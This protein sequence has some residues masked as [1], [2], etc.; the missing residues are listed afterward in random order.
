[1]MPLLIS[2]LILSCVLLQARHPSL[3]K[4]PLNWSHALFVGL[5][6]AGTFGL[7][8]L[9]SS[10]PPVGILIPLTLAATIGLRTYRSLPAAYKYVSLKVTDPGH[11]DSIVIDAQNITATD[12]P[13]RWAALLMRTLWSTILGWKVLLFFP[14]LILFGGL[15]GGLS[16]WAAGYTDERFANT[17][18]CW[19]MLLAILPAVMKKLHTLD[20]LPISR[21]LLFAFVIGPGLLSV[22][23]GYG[24]A[25]LIKA[26]P[27]KSVEHIRMMEIDDHFYLTVPAE[28]CHIM[29]SEPPPDNTSP[30]GE[31]HD[32]WR[33]GLFKDRRVGIYS[34]YSTP[35]GS[36]ID[37][38]AWQ[39]SR[40]VD[41]VYSTA[42]SSDAT[43]APITSWEPLDGSGAS[44][45]L[46]NSG[47]ETGAAH[48]PLFTLDEIKTRYLEIDA[49]GRVAPKGGALTILADYPEFKTRGRGRI[50]PVVMVIAF[51]P[52]FLLLWVYLA[53]F[54][55][56]S[57]RSRQ[58]WTAIVLLVGT[59]M[60]H[61]GG[62]AGA[63]LKYYALWVHTAF[64]KIII[65]DIDATIPGGTPALWVACG[66]LL[67]L[68]YWLAQRRFEQIEIPAAPRKPVD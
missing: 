64:V 28:N 62:F 46:G 40:A 8:V 51:V 65:R 63:I 15:F 61:L 38:V 7:V 6:L 23:T 55:P 29:W 33:A 58:T 16:S 3:R 49:A 5:T 18:I 22:V 25:E 21:K 11:S 26:A 12:S 27:S 30:W 52:F 44:P 31:S 37:F 68:G 10:L 66:L 43:S 32:A 41:N 53:A 20:A 17:A 1:M 9:L 45:T 60:L 47:D 14:F 36:S 2:V 13:G 54:A 19:Y 59:I 39:I 24:I 56:G 50:F 34:P 35:P 67:F 4:I 48:T 42:V 57:T